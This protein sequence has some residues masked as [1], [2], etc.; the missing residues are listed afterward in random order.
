M[1][2]NASWGMGLRA[3]GRRLEEITWREISFRHED[4]F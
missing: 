3:L 4:K 2:E 1:R